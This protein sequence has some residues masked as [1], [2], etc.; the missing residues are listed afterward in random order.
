MKI[1]YNVVHVSGDVLYAAR[2]GKIHSFSLQDGIHLS[3][4]KHPDVDKV[5]AA[6][7]AISGE[8]S[9]ETIANKDTPAVKGEGDDGPPAKRQKTEEP[10]DETTT[11]EANVQ[12]GAKNAEN[13]KSEG[14][15]KGGKKSK[16]RRNQQKPKEHNISRV[17]DRPVITHMTS[18]PDG[19][20]I[21]AITGH[22]KAIWVFENGEKGVLNQLSKRTL[23]KRPSNVVIGP[24]SQI[25]VADKFGDVY[26][27]PLL[28]DPTAQNATR[29]STPTV[30][31]PAY[32]PS[33]NTTTVHSKRNL[34]ALQE[35]QRQMELTT[36]N[37]N[38]KN[39]KS[40]GPDFEI[41]LLLGHV[42][43]LTGVA[44]G[45]SEGRRYI[46]TADRDEHIRVSRYIP[47]AHVIE[48]FC[49]GHTEFISSMTIPSSR[50]NVLV[51]GGGDENL[52]VWDWKANSL[53]SQ[54]SVLSL[55][56]KIIPDT[57]KVAITGLYNL[58]Y[59][60]EGSDLIYILT[61]CQDIPAIFSWQ[62]TEDN[63][64]HRPAI[65]QLPGNPLSLAIKPA[66]S[67]ESPKIVTAL[68]PSD[69]TQAKSL[70]IYSLTMTD[71]KLATSTTALVS[72]SDIESAELDVD[73]K[74]VRGLLYNTESL[75]KQPTEREE[76]RGEEQV[77]E[78]QAMGESE[79]I[80]E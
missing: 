70:A 41:T 52:F 6:V 40:E 56:Q 63:T 28:Y 65:I 31:K 80:E 47:Q 69:P 53:L 50:G 23:P 2:G 42:S 64:L 8:A 72:D 14:K 4:W 55:A 45:E 20:H 38:E 74:V 75:R 5:D 58:V 15:K 37:K 68:D 32:K 49:F 39:S 67:E 59:P 27:L 54:I 60:H 9:S 66:T 76:E 16:D 46:L 77:P 61:I 48:G 43:M 34:R 35:Q 30:A 13:A 33:A 11:A 19:A 12:E 29:S 36:R 78:D 18:S 21:L 10:K 79:V 7:K 3:T 24:D 62:L 44:I 73:E 1:P 17:P 25:V 57:T 51:T 26:S 22:D 71:E